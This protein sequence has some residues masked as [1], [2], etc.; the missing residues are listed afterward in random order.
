MKYIVEIDIDLPR[1]KVIELID[2]SEN[3]KYWQPGFIS[4]NHIEGIP[5]QRGALSK[6]KYKMGNRE[7]EMTEKIVVRDLPDVFAATY[8]AKDVVNLVTNRFNTIELNKTRWISENEFQ[9]SGMMRILSVFSQKS[10]EK[11]SCKYQYL[12]KN[13]A[14][15]N[16]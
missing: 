7:V 15:K 5:G 10:F 1:D 14:E 4:F 13:F 6:L 16:I 2:N 9:F 3:L 12:F 11:Q 8:T